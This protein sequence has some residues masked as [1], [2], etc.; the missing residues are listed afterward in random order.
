[1]EKTTKTGISSEKSS[2]AVDRRVSVAPMMDWTDDL[3]NVLRINDLA[4]PDKACLL[5]VSSKSESPTWLI[6]NIGVG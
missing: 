3:Q 1:V 6:A 4:S 5:Y 2:A